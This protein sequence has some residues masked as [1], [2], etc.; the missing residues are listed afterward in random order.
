[1]TALKSRRLSTPNALRLVP[2]A[3]IPSIRARLV[4]HAR[5]INAGSTEREHVTLNRRRLALL[6]RIN[7]WKASVPNGL[8]E[9]AEEEYED[10]LP[11]QINLPLPSFLPPENRN[12]DL[13]EIEQRLREALAFDCL[14]GLRK[15]LAE[16]VALLRE[17]DQYLRGQ[18]DNFRSQAAIKRVQGE[19]AFIAM[20]YRTTYAALGALGEDINADLMP[21][22]DGDISAANVF[23]YSRQLQRGSN[24]VNIS[25]I[26]RQTAIGPQVQNDNWL[27]EG[28]YSSFPAI[29][30]VPYLHK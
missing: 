18:A 22:A 12:A 16:R 1:M 24:S 23:E 30:F 27:E 10:I 2:V 3:Q 26:W 5:T 29:V 11:E 4:A 14:R 13:Q 8:G 17:K 25:W 21:L 7:A 20:R 9:D 19:I 6:E 15:R 28:M